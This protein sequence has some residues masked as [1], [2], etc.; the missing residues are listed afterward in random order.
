VLIPAGVL[1]SVRL[2]GDVA[3]A[4]TSAMRRGQVD[5]S[6]ALLALVH[7][8]TI[9][10]NPSDASVAGND[11]WTVDGRAITVEAAAA[12][13]NITPRAVRHR[14]ATGRLKALKLGGVWWI[15]PPP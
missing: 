11:R 4:L 2:A 13:L 1:V 9:A 10:A 7:E 8:L 14:I 3:G 5:T 6:P 15:E 12:V